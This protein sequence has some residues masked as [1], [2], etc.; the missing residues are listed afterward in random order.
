MIMRIVY[1]KYCDKVLQ[2]KKTFEQYVINKFL[3]P[4][5][6]A[7]SIPL[8]DGTRINFTAQLDILVE[9]YGEYD[10]MTMEVV[11]TIMGKRLRSIKGSIFRNNR[12]TLFFIF[13]SINS[14][15]FTFSLTDIVEYF[16]RYNK[17]FV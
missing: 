11:I 1:P 5:P 9:N 15:Y 14:D 4:Q 8:V 13:I 10:S 16:L 17:Y 12:K 6:F 2:C 3:D 7:L